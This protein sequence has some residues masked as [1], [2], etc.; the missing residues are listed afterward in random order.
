MIYDT[1]I[2]G[3]G[4]AGLTAAIYAQRAML[5]N[6]VIEKNYL[7]GGQV[8]NTYEVDNYPGLP[9]ESGFDISE[10]FRKHADDLG[11]VFIKDE[12][13]RI[14]D[15]EKNKKIYLKKSEPI[16]SKTVIIASGA[17]HKT[18][19]V[20]G[21]QKF[22]GKGVSYCATCDGAFFK[23][24][25]VAVIGGGDV[26][27]EDAAF[28]SPICRKVYFIHRRNELRAAKRL[29]ENL[30]KLKNIEFVWN[31]VVEEIVGENNVDGVIIHNKETNVKE[32]INVDGIFVAIGT[33]PVSSIFSDYVKMD[34][35]GYIIADENGITDKRGV[36]VCGD[37]RTKSLRQIITA[38][39]DGANCIHSVV[40]Y[41]SENWNVLK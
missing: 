13:V 24:K 5:K 41:L 29:Q 38:C 2:I 25:D 30:F 27:A 10:K 4:P 32:K 33:K 22:K 6:I 19:G 26:A 36:F 21:E 8:I 17:E 28:L 39:S 7:S 20:S 3:S 14:E 16:N 15:I 23:N 40:K 18:L 34:D 9:R 12:V 35:Y 37:V 11:A 1:V 31:S